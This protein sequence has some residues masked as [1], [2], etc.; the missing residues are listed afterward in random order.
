MKSIFNSSIKIKCKVVFPLIF[1]IFAGTLL[2]SCNVQLPDT[3]NWFVEPSLPPTSSQFPSSTN[4]NINISTKTATDSFLPSESPPANPTLDITSTPQPFATE[5]S[6]VTLTP[7][8]SPT[9]TLT[10]TRTLIPTRTRYPTFTP[11]PSRTKTVT[12]T[13]TPRLAYFRI[14]NL[15]QFSFATSPVRPEA[16]VSPGDDGIITVELI[17]EDGRSIIK[18]NFNYQNYMD[19][20]FGIA[21][22][23]EFDLNYASEYGRLIISTKDRFNRTIF[24]TSVD[25]ILLELG[26]NKITSPKDLTEPILIREPDY[27]DTVAGGM[28]IFEGLARTLNTNPIII[29]CIDPEGNILCEAQV[30]IEAPNQVL[31]HIPFQAYL[32]YSVTESTNVRLTIRQE[33]ASRLPGTIYLVSYEI[34]LDP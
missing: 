30:E 33:S 4:T 24:L 5:T 8:L 16:I 21:P 28:I 26:S 22:P 11:R 14:N 25:L 7:S 9:I 12:L 13:P 19:R 10:P 23:I 2:T 18:E 34:T 6:N 27:D 3:N 31:S 17:G 29:E 1:I 32:P 15:G 20:H